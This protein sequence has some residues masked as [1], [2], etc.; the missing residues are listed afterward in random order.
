MLP[1]KR[2]LAHRTLAHRTLAH[3]TLAHRTLAHRTLAHRT[4]AHRWAKVLR[5]LFQQATEQ[6][7]EEILN[8]NNVEVN[9]PPV[10]ISQ[11]GV[12]EKSNG[13]IRLIHDCSR[14]HGKSVNDHAP[15]LDKQRFESVDCATNLVKPN[16]YCSKVN[17]KGAYRSV[18][19][20]DHSQLI[21]GFTWFLD[22]KWRYFYD[23]KLPFGALP[24]V[25]S[26]IAG[27]KT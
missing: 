10:I 13:G 6:L 27:R 4:L 1:I 21:T 23:T 15:Q 14:P 3:R 18:N 11:I 2:T 19:I 20:S 7:R 8:G 16:S 17:L 26:S 5:P 9:V 22:G 24:F 12:I 25:S